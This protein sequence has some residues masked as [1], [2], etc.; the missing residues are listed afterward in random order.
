MPL[1][2]LNAKGEEGSRVEM[3]RIVSETHW[4]LSHVQSPTATVC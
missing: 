1:Y 4:L 3:V 2:R